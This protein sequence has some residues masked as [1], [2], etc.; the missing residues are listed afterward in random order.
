M[1]AG[2]VAIG[3]LVSLTAVGLLVRSIDV[4][5]AWATLSAVD[6]RW[7]LAPLAVVLSQFAIRT[8]RWRGLVAA[9]AGP[10]LPLQPVAAALAVGYLGNA[11]L[12]ARLGEVARILYLS[13]RSNVA[14]APATASVVLERAVDIAGLATI[15]GLAAGLAA[16]GAPAVLLL[17]PMVGVGLL[18]TRV[19]ARRVTAP[20]TGDATRLAAARRSLVRFLGAIA[21]ASVPALVVGYV[22]SVLAWLGDGVLIWACATSLGIPLGLPEAMAI[23]VGAALATLL[24]SAGGYVGTYELGVLTAGSVFGIPAPALLSLALVAHLMAVVPLALVGA[25]V[26]ARVGL[27]WRQSAPERRVDAATAA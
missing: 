16:S 15:A 1:R 2:R 17:V 18:G 22:L 19:V 20:P 26:V 6:L 11:I 8:L 10:H 21:G 5:S 9:A 3:L 27:G 4:G 7:L 13:R 14:L 25:V 12:P 23:G 24:P